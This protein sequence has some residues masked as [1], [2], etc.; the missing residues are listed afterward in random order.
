MG[1]T[2]K[3]RLELHY[4]TVYRMVQAM[5]QDLRKFMGNSCNRWKNQTLLR[6]LFLAWTSTPSGLLKMWKARGLRGQEAYS[7]LY[8]VSP[9]CAMRS[10]I[11]KRTEISFEKQRQI[12]Q[13]QKE[14]V[15]L[16][17]DLKSKSCFSPSFYQTPRFYGT[18][19]VGRYTLLFNPSSVSPS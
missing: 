12:I 6:P 18:A 5:L 13:Y 1:D 14:I 3:K 7:P 19:F 15:L 10:A 16:D 11:L 8:L 2:K 9:Q 17:R 4:R